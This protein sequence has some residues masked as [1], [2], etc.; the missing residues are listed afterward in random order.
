MKDW[1]IENELALIHCE[2]VNSINL[3]NERKKYLIQRQKELVGMRSPKKIA[4]M[5]QEKGLA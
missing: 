2:L 1:Q 5:E 3:S 4:Q